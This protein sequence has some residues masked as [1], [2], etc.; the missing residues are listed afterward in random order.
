MTQSRYKSKPAIIAII[1]LV[2]FIIKNY[3]NIDIPV[4]DELIELILGV[5]IAFGVYNNPLDKE[6]Y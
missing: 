6:H 5:L 3:V 4:S 1:S 2:L